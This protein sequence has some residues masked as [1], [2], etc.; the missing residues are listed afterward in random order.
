MAIPRSEIITDGEIGVYHCISRCVR[1]AFLCG[2][3]RLSGKNFDHRKDWAERRLKLLA[4]I[5]AV[6]VGGRSIMENHLH[7]VLR[8]RPDI[9]NSWNNL[10]VAIR[11]RR[12]YPRKLDDREKELEIKVLSEDE[13]KI[14]EYRH[15]LQ[16]ISWFMKS[17]SEYIA[18]RANKEDDCTGRF[19]EGRFKSTELLDEEAILSCLVYVDLNPIRA[20]VADSPEESEYTSIK[21]RIIGR[22]AREKLR[23][24]GID[25]KETPCSGLMRKPKVRKIA[26]LSQTDA[27]LAPL[28]DFISLSEDEYISLVDVSGRIVREGKRGVVPEELAPILERLKIEPSG[29]DS[30]ITG[31]NHTFSRAA[32]SFESLQAKAMS[33]NKSWIKGFSA[34]Q[35]LFC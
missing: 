4:S 20:R 30:L 9:V 11:W 34:S 1:R 12:L 26:E 13:E 28:S 5:F 33:L 15:R 23:K 25:L 18:R 7:T 17:L 2:E 19:W 31:F 27:W 21:E 16:S 6:D 14:E 24:M 22:Q 3:D 8:N 35:E 29:W 32:G 10:E